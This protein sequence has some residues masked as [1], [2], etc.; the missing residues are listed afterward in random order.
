MPIREQVASTEEAAAPREAADGPS[1]RPT[2]PVGHA[3]GPGSE[4]FGLAAG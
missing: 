4:P 3:R 1:T 2:E